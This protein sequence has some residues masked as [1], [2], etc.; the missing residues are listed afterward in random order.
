MNLGPGA[1]SAVPAQGTG[2]S[3]LYLKYPQHCTCST[4]H[5]ALGPTLLYTPY[6][7]I[8]GHPILYLQCSSIPGVLGPQCNT[9]GAGAPVQ[10]LGC[11][12][13]STIPGVLGPQY[14][15]WG[16]GAPVQCLGCW[17]PSTIPGVLGPQY[18]TWGAGAHSSEVCIARKPPATN[19]PVWA[20]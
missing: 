2:P 1:C 10:Y 3:I 5:W 15:T 11:W 20:E 16:A 18:N 13:P 6:Y 4:I 9:W 12:G 7:T 17:S 8:H 14:N 19:S